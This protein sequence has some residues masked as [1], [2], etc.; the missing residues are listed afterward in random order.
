MMANYGASTRTNVSE[1][2][3]GNPDCEH[4]GS[5]PVTRRSFLSQ[6]FQSIN[7]GDQ[8]GN[9]IARMAMRADA[10]NLAMGTES[11]LLRQFKNDK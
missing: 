3:H 7:V 6:E 9:A 5:I 8:D 10:L 1:F 11:P 4:S 2:G